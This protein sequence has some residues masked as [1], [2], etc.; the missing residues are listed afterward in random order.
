M[1]KNTQE[2]KYHLSEKDIQ[3]IR[4]LRTD[5]PYTWTR[6]K[7]AEKFECSQFFVG[8]ICEAPVEKKEL[9]RGK[10]EAIKER[11]GRRRRYARD[12]RGKRRELWA[13]D[14]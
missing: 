1:R 5:D 14:A 9:E 2:K 4:K 10:L 12:D 6:K 8:M 11:W 3:E 7:L 13:R